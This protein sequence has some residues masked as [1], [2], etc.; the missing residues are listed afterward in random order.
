M[1]EEWSCQQ[2]VLEELDTSRGKSELQLYFTLCSKINLI[3][4]IDLRVKA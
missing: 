3:W 1:E 2:L 4:S